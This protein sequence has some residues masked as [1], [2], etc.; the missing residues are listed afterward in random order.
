MFIF[1]FII[2]SRAVFLDVFSAPKLRKTMIL[3]EENT[4]RHFLVLLGKVLNLSQ[5]MKVC[6]LA[7]KFEEKLNNIKINNIMYDSN[8]IVYSI[9]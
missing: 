2:K 6:S 5:M 9:T 4:L 7:L 8:I 1:T 3:W